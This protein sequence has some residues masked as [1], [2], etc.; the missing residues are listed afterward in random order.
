M[1]SPRLRFPAIRG[2]SVAFF[3]LFLYFLHVT[4][5]CSDV[6]AQ[7]ETTQHYSS[8]F[9]V[10]PAHWKAA[11]VR[12]WSHKDTPWTTLLLVVDARLCDLRLEVI[13]KLIIIIIIILLRV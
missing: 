1:G 13:Y 3:Y 11:L 4:H 8:T 9:I 2:R 10:L 7:V 12:G 6:G 5:P